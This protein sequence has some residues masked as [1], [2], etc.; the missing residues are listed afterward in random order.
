[1]T[2]QEKADA[3]RL[4]DDRKALFD[5]LMRI[6]YIPDKDMRGRFDDFCME[7]RTRIMA[8]RDELMGI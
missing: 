2:P 7:L 3:W 4:Y 6:G 5:K 1:M 8:Q